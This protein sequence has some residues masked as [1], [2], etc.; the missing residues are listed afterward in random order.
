MEPSLRI[1]SLIKKTI[2]AKRFLS[3]EQAKIITRV[4]S[5]NENS[6][7]PLKRALA[8]AA[9][10][11]EIPIS[12]D[13]EEIIVGNRTPDVR[14]GV[15]FPEAGISWLMDEMNSLPLRQQDPFNVKK[16][17]KIAFLG[18]IAPYWKGKTLEDDI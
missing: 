14:A 17:D 16:E 8:L 12:I 9:S 3:L 1:K 13:P 4:Y 2:S 7:L 11:K 15:V 18:E 6:P 10:L 5:E